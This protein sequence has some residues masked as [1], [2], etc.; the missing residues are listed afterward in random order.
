MTDTSSGTSIEINDKR[1]AA[2]FRGV[3]FSQFQKSK[4]KSELY[5]HSSTIK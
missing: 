5:A 4:V 2:D 1:A 3:S